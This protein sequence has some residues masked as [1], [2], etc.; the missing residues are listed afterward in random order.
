MIPESHLL[1]EVHQWWPH[2]SA[3]S[4]QRLEEQHD[5]VVPDDVREE[6]ERIIGSTVD[7]SAQLSDGDR[8]FIRTQQEMVD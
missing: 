4:K 1:P 8:T 2:L 6:I 5:G 3:R 7:P